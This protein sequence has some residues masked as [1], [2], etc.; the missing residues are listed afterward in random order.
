MYC[1]PYYTYIYIK[2][3]QIYVCIVYT[4]SHLEIF[5]TI[6]RLLAQLKIFMLAQL[7][8]SPGKIVRYK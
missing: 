2:H 5:L 6:T 7:P 8:E 4:T 1:V 3:T